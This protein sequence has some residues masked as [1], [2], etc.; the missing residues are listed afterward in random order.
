MTSMP[1][2][3]DRKGKMLISKYMQAYPPKEALNS[4]YDSR[5]LKLQ[6]IIIIKNQQALCNRSTVGKARDIPRKQVCTFLKP[7]FVTV[8]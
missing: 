4:S 3:L 8:D 5:D 7:V 1:C 6:T 2:S